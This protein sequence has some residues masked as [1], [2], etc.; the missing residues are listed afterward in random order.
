[1]NMVVHVNY[2][3]FLKDLTKEQF[4]AFML[5]IVEHRLGRAFLDDRA[6]I[7][8]CDPV[9]G[10]AGKPHL[11]GDDDHGRSVGG[12]FLHQVEDTADR[13]RVEGRRRLVERGG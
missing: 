10:L 3:R 5:R 13:F 6:F 4:G 11:V 8:K 1:M 9:G 12:Q 2:S 7:H